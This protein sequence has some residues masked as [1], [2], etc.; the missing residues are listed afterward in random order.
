MKLYDRWGFHTFLLNP[1]AISCGLGDTEP[2]LFTIIKHGPC[3]IFWGALIRRGISPGIVVMWSAA[4][5]E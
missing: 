3:R 4:G 2:D 1:L 5:N